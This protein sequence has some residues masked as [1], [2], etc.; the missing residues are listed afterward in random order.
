MPAECLPKQKDNSA[1]RWCKGVRHIIG[2]FGLRGSLRRLPGIISNYCA[3][4]KPMI[5]KYSR[6]ISLTQRK[7]LSFRAYMTGDVS[8]EI[9]R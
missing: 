8:R 9:S 4:V 2:S 6:R 5:R 1:K 3:N 7:M